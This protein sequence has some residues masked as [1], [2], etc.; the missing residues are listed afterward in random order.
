LLELNFIEI[1]Y[2]KHFKNIKEFEKILL[3]TEF[4]ELLGIIE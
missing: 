1:D 3:K 2:K 4:N